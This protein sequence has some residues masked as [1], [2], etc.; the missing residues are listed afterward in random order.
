[1]KTISFAAAA[2]SVVLSALPARAGVVITQQ[3]TANLQSGPRQS[4]QTIMIQGNK[5][6]MVT[7]EREIIT[8]LDNS[9]MYLIDPTKSSYFQ[10]PFPPTG[11]MAQAVAHAAGA[12]D[13]KRGTTTRK[14]LGYSCTDYTG[15]GQ[16]MSGDFTV[17]ECFSTAAP[18]AK[19][20]NAFQKAMAAKLKSVVPESNTPDGIPLASESTV[21]MNTMKLPNLPPEQAQRLQQQLAKMKPVTTKTEVTKLEAKNLPPETFAVPK[22]FTQR[23][24]GMPPTGQAKAPA[25]APSPA[26]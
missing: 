3:Q 24:L 19:E 2:L 1:M 20:F 14:V 26:K 13:F 16:S 22:G 9:V 25:P 23:T 10:L 7:G 11:P 4:E 21:H 17:T 8:D 15:T 12:M 6:K 18:G 5:Q